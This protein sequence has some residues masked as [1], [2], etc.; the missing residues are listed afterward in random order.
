MLIGGA[1]INRSFGRRI[2]HL[3]DGRPYAG[4]VFYCT[5]AFEG[6]D[7]IE[8]LSTPDGMAGLQRARQAEADKYLAEVDARA[9][10][11]PRR[12]AG[13]ARRP[14]ARA[15]AVGAV[16]RARG[17]RTTSRWTTSGPAWI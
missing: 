16:P 1:A 17:W 6:L 8:L 5:D 7:T 10:R 11:A 4:G 3:E 9:G 14:A 2:W 12:R 13:P 15:G